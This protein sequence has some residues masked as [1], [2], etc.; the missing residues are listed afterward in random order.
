MNYKD[1]LDLCKK[2]KNFK[3]LKIQGLSVHIGSQITNIDPFK[4]TLF[5]L[6]R[7]IRYK[8]AVIVMG[9]MTKGNAKTTTNA[10]SSTPCVAQ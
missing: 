2:I 5:I 3:N 10:S 4:K 1:C 7:I 9:G 6:N 8:N